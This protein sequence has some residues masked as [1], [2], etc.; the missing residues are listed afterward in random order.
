[1]GEPPLFKMIEPD[2]CIATY[3][4]SQCFVSRRVINYLSSD[5]IL[6]LDDYRNI[7][8]EQGDISDKLSGILI[9]ITYEGSRHRIIISYCKAMDA[10]TQNLIRLSSDDSMIRLDV[11]RT[12]IYIDYE[13]N[14]FTLGSSKD[15][16]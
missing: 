15:M 6:H 14:V 7:P 2:K 12:S 8:L 1:M 10:T 11:D 16:C 13:Q 4:L 5:V 3:Y 9:G